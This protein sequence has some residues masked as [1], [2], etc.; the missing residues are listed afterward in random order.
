M[1]RILTENSRLLE[2]GGYFAVFDDRSLKKSIENYP[3]KYVST[4]DATTRSCHSLVRA[5]QPSR[6]RCH[7]LTSCFLQVSELRLHQSTRTLRWCNG[8]Q[9]FAN[10]KRRI[11]EPQVGWGIRPR[12]GLP[13]WHRK[14]RLAIITNKSLIVSGVLRVKHLII[15]EP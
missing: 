7:G 4:P 11:I 5:F 9:E 3:K 15:L 2:N 6:I 14:A 8:P 13:H 12:S 10:S 1:F